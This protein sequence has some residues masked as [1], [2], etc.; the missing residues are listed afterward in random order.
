MISAVFWYRE[1]QAQRRWLR[2]ASGS[3][4]DDRTSSNCACHIHA[5]AWA[6]YTMIHVS[7]GHRSWLSI[8]VVLTSMRLAGLTGLRYTLT[9]PVRQPLL[10][11]SLYMPVSTP[12]TST[13]PRSRLRGVETRHRSLTLVQGLYNRGEHASSPARRQPLPWAS[14]SEQRTYM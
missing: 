4:A 9:A 13:K 14:I 10:R 8:A 6:K 7:E 3:G 12:L 2:P 1:V 11:Q 5:T